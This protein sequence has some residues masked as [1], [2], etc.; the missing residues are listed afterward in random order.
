MMRFTDAVGRKVVSTSTAETVGRVAEFV[1][2]PGQRR[3]VAVQVKKSAAGKS[4]RW[5]DIAAFGE[6]AV[7]V[8]GVERLVDPDEAV[9]ALL[10]KNH[11]LLGRRVLDTLGDEH[12]KLA[13]VE[14]DP[15]TAEITG[16]VLANG[17]VP[18]ERLVGVGSWAVVIRAE[19][20]RPGPL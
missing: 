6:D 1:V 2:D 17:L 11:H 5:S 20:A 10:G 16:L 4:L 14:F 13:D 9:V 3:I 7:T 8:T 15:A 12:G 18:G 19:D